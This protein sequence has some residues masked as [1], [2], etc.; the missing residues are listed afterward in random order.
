[1]SMTFEPFGGRL[2]SES[3]EINR[4]SPIKQILQCGM[5]WQIVLL[6][7][8]LLIVVSVTAFDVYWSFKT[9]ELLPEYELNP[10]GNLLIHLD[11]GDI[12]LFMTCKM[13]G[14]MIVLLSVPCMFVIRRWWGL[15][16]AVSLACGQIAL[17]LFLCL[18]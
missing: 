11:N 15:A 16:A 2:K 10:L 12:A 13:M 4:H 6:A 14:T 8:S 18:A 7:S 9:I 3:S 1:M 5:D 17:L